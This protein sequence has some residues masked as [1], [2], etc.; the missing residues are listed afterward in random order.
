MRRVRE[1]LRLKYEVGATD[2][3]VACS[4]G[5]ARNTARLCLTGRRQRG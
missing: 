4:V 2:W 5:A 3:A 1:I